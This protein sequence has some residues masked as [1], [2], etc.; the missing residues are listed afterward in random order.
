MC[1][2]LIAADSHRDYS[3]VVAANRDEFHDRPT[4]AAAFWADRPWILGGRDLK[5]GGTWL[6]IDR[7]GR[8]A[9]VTN[10]RQGE[11]EPAAPRSRGLLV[12]DYLAAEI[13]ARTHIQRVECDAGLYNGFNLMA[14]DGRELLYFS[15]RE[16]R[17]RV[18]DPGVYGLSNHLLDTA[19]PKVTTGKGALNDLLLG[20]ESKLVP[21]LLA[22]LA[23]PRQAADESLP[24]TGIGLA[25][26]RLLSAAFIVSG[27]YGTRSSTVVLVGRDGGVVFVERSFGANGVPAGE[28][29]HQFQVDGADG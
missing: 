8:F 23:D 29:R 12:S 25:W 27:E 1:L 15:N 20:A 7:R 24:S 10:Y 6:G 13:D 4:A 3:L 5:A 19:W 2:I 11:R 22:L 16:G 18:L 28:V 14:G 17:A 21:N 26:E 9:A